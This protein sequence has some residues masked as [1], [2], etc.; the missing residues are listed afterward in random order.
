MNNI[1]ND[2]EYF[3]YKHHFKKK[4]DNLIC[5]NDTYLKK[6]LKHSSELEE[7]MKI[8]VE[9]GS[10]V[11]IIND[12]NDSYYIVSNFTNVFK[13]PNF[14]LNNFP[15]NTSNKIAMLC[16]ASNG[17]EKKYINLIYSQYIYCQKYN[18]DYI[19]FTKYKDK[20]NW[21]IIYKGLELQK[22]NIY[23]FMIT[24]DA[25]I[26][27]DYNSPNIISSLNNK[28]DIFLVNGIS[29]RVNS[30]MIVLKNENSSLEFFQR[31]LKLKDYKKIMPENRVSVA[32]ENG[33]VIQVLNDTFFDDKKF[34]LDYKWNNTLRNRNCYFKHYTNA[35][36]MFFNTDN[37]NI[38][39]TFK[40]D[41]LYKILIQMII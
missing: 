8:K 31:V 22:K 11:N 30:G 33:A 19:L 26:F 10:E 28:Y 39:E 14:Y 34:I 20:P 5:S 6:S 32:G 12:F 24:I 29:K 17:Y 15:C 38:Y 40:N 37:K 25:D 27:I 13:L 2:S 35:M 4:S 18:F 1:L 16:T 41:K 21:E 36:T 9:I 7:N 3:A 23:D